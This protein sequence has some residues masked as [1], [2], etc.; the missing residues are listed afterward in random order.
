MSSVL[1][2]Q[3]R[4][5]SAS[6]RRLD[7]SPA[8]SKPPADLWVSDLRRISSLLNVATGPTPPPVGLRAGFL[9]TLP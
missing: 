2:F 5:P 9:P 4:R 7:T 8:S 3:P 1:Q 6:A